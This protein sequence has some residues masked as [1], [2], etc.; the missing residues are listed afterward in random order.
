MD[1]DDNSTLDRAAP[2]RHGKSETTLPVQSLMAAL[3][4]RA[5]DPASRLLG[6]SDQRL[7]PRRL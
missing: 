7:I 4:L 2:P 3:I 6:S 1:N 5:I